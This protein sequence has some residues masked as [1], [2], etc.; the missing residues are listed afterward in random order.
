MEAQEETL[1]A[2]ASPLTTCRIDWLIEA[3]R[4]EGEREK[5][6]SGGQKVKRERKNEKNAVDRSTTMTTAWEGK[7]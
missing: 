5:K 3:G 6:R 2:A 4:K 1:E 7:F